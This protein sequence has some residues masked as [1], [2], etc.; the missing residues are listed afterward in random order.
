MH[1]AFQSYRDRL[2]S[3]VLMI[4]FCCW[5]IPAFAQHF[6]VSADVERQVEEASPLAN[7]YDG[8]VLEGFRLFTNETFGGNGR[9]CASCHPPT[10]NFTLDPAFIR[11]LPKHDPLFV[12][13]FNPQ[14]RALERPALMRTYGLIVE[15]LDGFDRPGVLRA[16]PHTLGL[17]ETVAKDQGDA[18]REPFPLVHMTG[19]SGD[20]AP[21]NGS[22]HNFALGAVIQHFPRTLTRR[23]CSTSQFDPKTCDFRLPT[24]AELSALETFQ[25]FLGRQA[26]IDLAVMTFTDPYVQYGK[27]LFIEAPAAPSPSNPTSTTRSCNGCHRNAGANDAASNGRLFDTGGNR[28]PNAPACRRPGQAPGDGGY[29]LEPV[30]TQSGHV[31]CGTD[32][33]FTI[34]FRGTNEFNTP[35]LIE[36]ADTPPYF[37]NNIVDTIEEAVEFYN[38]DVFGNSPAGGGQPFALSKLQVRK[39]AAFLRAL[40]ALDNMNNGN[41]FNRLAMRQS[42][43]RPKLAIAAVRIA[44]SETKDAIQVLTSGP[45]PLYQGSGVIS[46]LQAALEIENRAINECNTALLTKA[47][48]RKDKARRLMLAAN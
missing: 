14:L 23:S 9:T 32:K 38:G 18:S 37:H 10:N 27:K 12:A 48:E 31:M 5:T 40:N 17:H 21:G 29:G 6:S 20:G 4:F 33:D 3:I 25:R 45:L 30:S 28:H 46:H 42:S 41:R 24:K 47:I 22:L 43:D 35:S 15:N 19:W 34:T 13:E 26:E 11:Q 36:A 44:A 39:I 2:R 1:Q 7:D 8:T 16:V